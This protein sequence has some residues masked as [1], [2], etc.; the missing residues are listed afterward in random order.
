MAGVGEGGERGGGGKSTM[1]SS[2]GGG[3]GKLI[4]VAIASVLKGGEST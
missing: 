1:A 3:G 4:G 2:G